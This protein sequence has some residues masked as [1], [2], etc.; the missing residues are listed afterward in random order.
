VNQLFGLEANRAGWPGFS[1]QTKLI[2]NAK[3][4]SPEYLLVVLTKFFS[5]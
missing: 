4:I 3:K 5:C 2:N 1:R